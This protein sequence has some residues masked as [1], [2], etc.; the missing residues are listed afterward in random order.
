MILDDE[1]VVGKRLGPALDKMGCQTE[2]FVEP[3]QALKRLE[4][5]EFDVVVTD[6][7]MDQTDGIQVLEQVK[8]RWPRTKVVVISGYATLEVA[9]EALAKGAFDLLAKPFKP[10]DLRQVVARAA[11]SLG[12][13]LSV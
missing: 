8:A 4:D 12:V 6:I 2:T 11:Q 1:E 7:R 13:P 9:R 3:A 5:N 10:E